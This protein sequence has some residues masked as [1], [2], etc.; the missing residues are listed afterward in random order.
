MHEQFTYID[1][2]DG[3]KLSGQPVN[4]LPGVLFNNRL[5]APCRPLS[6]FLRMASNL[7]EVGR[8]EI[9]NYKDK[10]MSVMR[11]GLELANL[12]YQASKIK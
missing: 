8:R 6:V 2:F 12:I 9:F 10:D 4:V 11:N 5:V 7:I 3:G 1:P